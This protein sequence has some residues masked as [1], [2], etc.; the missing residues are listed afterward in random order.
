M[1]ILEK[2]LVKGTDAFGQ[3]IKLKAELEKNKTKSDAY[4]KVVKNPNATR[5]ER[6]HAED[7]SLS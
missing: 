1:A 4:D 6:R 5:E 2:L 7:D 3:Y